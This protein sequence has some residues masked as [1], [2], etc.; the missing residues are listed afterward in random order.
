LPG[1]RFFRG[2]QKQPCPAGFRLPTDTEW[3][4][5]WVSWSSSNSAGAF[6]SPLKLVA[7]GRRGSGNCSLGLVDGYGFYWSSTVLGLNFGSGLAD[8]GGYTRAFGFS[9]RCLKD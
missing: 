2:R 9:V 8:A 4:A 7:A 5:E 6:G 3:E 1:N